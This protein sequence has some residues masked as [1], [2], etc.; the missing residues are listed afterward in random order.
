M[1]MGTI[2]R[3]V[4]NPRGKQGQDCR[5]WSILGLIV[6]SLSCGRRGMKAAFPLGRGLTDRQ[7]A[8]LGFHRGTTPCHAPPTETLR[9]L[10]GRALA[11]ILGALPLADR[12]KAEHVLPAFCGGLQ[13]VLGHEASRGKGPE[14]PDALK[15]LERLGL[16]GK[17]VTGDAI[18]CQRSITVKIVEG[19]GSYLLPVKVNQK[20][21]KDNIETAIGKVRALCKW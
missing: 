18:F 1:D 14:I 15:L 7:K 20:T 5:L 17:I 13:T 2:L 6:V 16:H 8:R 11:D 4:P 19:G 12:G 9:L 21:L 3:R 10:D